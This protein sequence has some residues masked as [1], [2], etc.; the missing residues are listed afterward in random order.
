MNKEQRLAAAFGTS[1]SV[2]LGISFFVVDAIGMQ[3]WGTFFIGTP[4]T[5]LLYS[6]VD[7]KLFGGKQ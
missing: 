3:G 6:A 7:Y 5:Y 1:L 2:W 4:L